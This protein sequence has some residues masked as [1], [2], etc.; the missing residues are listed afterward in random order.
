MQSGGRGKWL[1]L[2]G[3]VVALVFGAVFFSRDNGDMLNPMGESLGEDQDK[4]KPYDKYSFERLVTREDEVSQIDIQDST[5]SY[6]SEGKK[7]TGAI[8]LP[9]GPGPEGGWPVVLMLRGYA[10]KEIY[11]TG[12][13]TKNG[14]KYYSEHGYVTLAPDFLGYGGSDPEDEDTLGARVRRPVAVLDL[15]ASLESLEMIDTSRVY[16][17]GH[18]NGGQIAL[19][20]LEIL[21]QRELRGR[22]PKYSLRAATL[23]APVSRPFPYSILYYTYD[24][25]DRGRALRRAVSEW[26]EDYLADDYSVEHY[27]DWIRTPIQVHQGTADEAVP[28]N[29]SDELVETLEELN[30]EIEYYR[31]SGVDHNMRPSWDTVVVRDVAWFGQYP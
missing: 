16:L 30:K 14:A 29:W 22:T 8:T 3:V 23:W 31:Y 5:F 9:T 6:L 11:Y 19:S 18:S 4:D 21:G 15:L 27:W 28:V 25:D 13:G 20:V 24:W 10:D 17:W 7:I 12:Y 1:F 26:E 2:V